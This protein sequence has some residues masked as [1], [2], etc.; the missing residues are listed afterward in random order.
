MQHGDIQV[1]QQGNQTGNEGRG[2]HGTGKSPADDVG[3]EEGIQRGHD[4]VQEG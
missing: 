4:G 2:D 3:K 1:A